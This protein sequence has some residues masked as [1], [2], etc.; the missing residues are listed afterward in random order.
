MRTGAAEPVPFLDC[1]ALSGWATQAVFTAVTFGVW[2]LQL[3]AAMSARLKHQ[4]SDTQVLCFLRFE[5]GIGRDLEAA[6]NC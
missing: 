4:Q 2:M 6:W 3:L 5:P 1:S